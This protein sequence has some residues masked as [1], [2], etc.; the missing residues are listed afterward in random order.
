MLRRCDGFFRSQLI[1]DAGAVAV[2]V[3]KL[4]LLLTAFEFVSMVVDW[5]ERDT[6]SALF[7]MAGMALMAMVFWGAYTRR[8][9][10]LSTYAL[11]GSV[12]LLASIVWTGVELYRT[13]KS[14]QAGSAATT[15]LAVRQAGAGRKMSDADWLTEVDGG[16]QGAGAVA[17][18]FLALVLSL[19]VLACKLYLINLA[20]RMAALL[21]APLAPVSEPILAEPYDPAQP[22]PPPVTYVVENSDGAAP[23]GYLS[24]PPLATG[25]TATYAQL[26]PEGPVGASRSPAVGTAPPLS[27][28]PSAP[29]AIL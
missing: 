20:L 26:P 16:R 14:S 18:A 12:L 19:A 23:T 8:R 22:L 25:T 17:V 21:A 11:C 24:F 2:R 29:A 13:L 7:A 3:E 28:L 10:A 9:W 27:S 1:D 4:V 5:T 6:V 15:R